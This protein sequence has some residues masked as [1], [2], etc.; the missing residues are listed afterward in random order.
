M[1]QE[2]WIVRDHNESLLIERECLLVARN[3][4]AAWRMAGGKD[5]GNSICQIDGDETRIANKVA[6]G[7][8]QGAKRCSFTLDGEH[9]FA[10]EFDEIGTCLHP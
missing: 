9:Y 3:F 6:E 8:K 1:S 10:G 5:S 4:D 2:I 7:Q